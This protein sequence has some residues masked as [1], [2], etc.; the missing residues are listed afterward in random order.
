MWPNIAEAVKN[1]VLES[2]NPLLDSYRPK[3]ILNVLKLTVFDLGDVPIVVDGV[4]ASLSG[5]DTVIDMYFHWNSNADIHLIAEAIGGVEVE[6]VIHGLQY[7]S[8]ARLFLGPHCSAWP[9][10]GC[11]SVTFVGKPVLDFGIKAAKIPLEAIPGFSSWLRGFVEQMLSWSLTYPNRLVFP[12]FNDMGKMKLMERTV[13][14]IG[15][16]T[17]QIVGADGI[18][19]SFFQKRKT[20]VQGTRTNGDARTSISKRTSASVTGKSPR[21]GECLVFPVYKAPNER[22]EL[23]LMADETKPPVIGNMLIKD[24]V[25][26][27][28][29]ISVGSLLDHENIEI[30]RRLVNPAKTTA[31]VGTLTIVAT[32]CQFEDRSRE[33]EQEYDEGFDAHADATRR[34]LQDADQP[35]LEE[36]AMQ[37]ASSGQGSSGAFPRGRGSAPFEARRRSSSASRLRQSI[38]R[39]VPIRGLLMVDIVSCSNLPKADLVGSSD[40]YVKIRLGRQME[41][42]E[43]VSN[44]LNPVYNVQKQFDVDDVARDVLEVEVHDYDRIKVKKRLLCAVNIDVKSV[45]EAG[46]AIAAKSYQLSGRGGSTSGGGGSI[47]LGLRLLVNQ[48]KTSS[49][50]GGTGASS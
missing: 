29:T 31:D 17:I 13:D 38:T 9:C 39:N 43:H 4:S 40:P 24:N 45:F 33:A 10:F 32:F 26:G 16:L 47:M 1:D 18:P 12:L 6:A 11:F 15:R 44:N 34:F 42:T 37:D 41:Q 22:I 36:A 2:V 25:I 20:Y 7:Q 14:P 27:L 19:E 5:N 23:A 48:E 50:Q 30:T 35:T 3:A 8:V 46:G 49:V 28:L 21:F